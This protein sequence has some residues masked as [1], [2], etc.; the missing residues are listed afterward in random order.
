MPYL[1]VVQG[2]QQGRKISLQGR[3][4]YV[5]GRSANSY[6]VMTYP[7]VSKFHAMIQ[8]VNGEYFLVDGDGQRASRNGTWLNGQRISREPVRLRHQDRI[9]ICDI[10]Y[11]FLDEDSNEGLVSS[12]TVHATVSKSGLQLL[13]AQP[14]ERLKEL[15]NLLG[16]LTRILD[17]N[18]L[19]PRIVDSLFHVF[20]KADRAFII[21]RDNLEQDGQPIAK[22]IKTR[23][24][25]DP[26]GTLISSG[27]VRSCI[28]TNQAF[29]SEDTSMIN[30]S[31]SVV[32]SGMRS[33]IV[34]PL[35]F[36]N[37][38]KAF[39]V[40]QLDTQDWTKRFTQEDLEFLMAVAGQAAI[41]IENAQLHEAERARD[42]LVR[43]MEL[44]QSVQQSFLPRRLPQVPGYEFFAYYQPAQE[45]GGDYYDFVPLANR[46]LA[47]TIGD[48]AGK[49]VPAA[50][51]MAKISSE[52]RF[53]LFHH[54]EQPHVA[55]MALNEYLHEADLAQR[56][57][58]M[59]AMV[60]DPV[61]HVLT[62]A[63]A[64]H[65]PP[66]I[67]RAA[68]GQIEEAIPLEVSGLP[69]GVREEVTYEARTISLEVGDCMIMFSD[70]V[71]SAHDRDHNYLRIAGILDALRTGPF[72]A[73]ELGN[74][75]VQ[76]V[77]RHST[78]CQQ[79]DDVTIVCF[80]RTA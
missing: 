32:A 57:M 74:R 58:T 59:A 45:V 65:D 10:V 49:G 9:D 55:L 40:I 69:L 29:L 11:L 24:P 35:T 34:A 22:V 38:D 52:A 73:T 43:D 1:A 64:A 5:L 62:V 26:T 31:Q 42:R 30:P 8:R 27:I 41:A 56:F 39:G 33:V 70:G 48:V 25:D 50:L 6:V 2:P 80:G 76:T 16:D 71:T 19:L 77:E 54:P 78:G 61:R 67:Y 20:R 46:R 15:L 17:L 44:A 51:L 21:L 79:Q 7:G 47:I 75:L 28:E 66:L 12:S 13:E 14:A 18:T 72:T 37:E 23:R 68:T 63:N 53:S 36:R 60:L 4:E 3:D